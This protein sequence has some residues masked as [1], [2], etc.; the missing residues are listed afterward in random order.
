ME[1]YSR[2]ADCLYNISRALVDSDKIP[3][4]LVGNKID[5]MRNR[6]ITEQG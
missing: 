5:L 1:S 3:V 2:A 6:A 4:V